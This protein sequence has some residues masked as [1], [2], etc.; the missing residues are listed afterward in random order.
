MPVGKAAASVA[1]SRPMSACQGQS[2]WRNQAPPAQCRC[3]SSSAARRTAHA[4]RAPARGRPVF[5]PASAKQVGPVLFR[6]SAAMEPQE[7]L[8]FYKVR[9]EHE[10][11]FQHVGSEWRFEQPALLRHELR[12]ED[13]P[14]IVREGSI[15]CLDATPVVEGVRRRNQG[16][17]ALMERATAYFTLLTYTTSGVGVFFVRPSF[18]VL[19]VLGAGLVATAR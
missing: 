12:R 19:C 7:Q 5:A 17:G 15:C 16:A 10:M 9:A 3:N 18:D 6:Q 11:V 8:A 4:P 2:R 13:P 1:A 14:P